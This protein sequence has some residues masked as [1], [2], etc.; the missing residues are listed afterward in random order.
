MYVK[1]LSAHRLVLLV[2]LVAGCWLCGRADSAATKIGPRSMSPTDLAHAI[3]RAIQE[4]LETEK[5][6]ASPR[7]DD[8]EFMRRAYLDVT[9]IIPTAEQAA[10]F[11][12]GKN[13]HKRA[14]LVNELLASPKYGQHMAD[15]W[16][17]L[18][19]P[20]MT[21]ETRALDTNALGR[22]LAERFNRNQ[23]WN[24][25]VYDFVTATG[26]V[27][28]NGA[29]AFFIANPTADK[30]T[31]SVTRLFLGI[32]LQC[33][34]CHNHPFTAWKQTEYWG[35]AAFFTK[36]KSDRAQAATK[37]GTSPG[38]TEMARGK[39][40][41]LPESAKIVPARFLTGEMPPLKPGEP[42]R[43]A[44]AKWLTSAGNPYFA[45]A[46]VNRMWGHFFGRGLVHPVDNMHDDNPASHPELLKLLSEQFAASGFDV[47]Q[48]I[49]AIC[50]S[51]AYQRTSKP[52]G[53]NAKYANLFGAVGIKALTPEQLFDSLTQVVGTPGA[54]A[55]GLLAKQKKQNPAATP[56]SQFAR[57]FRGDVEADS[58]EYDAGIP[59]ALRLMNSPMLNRRAVL[60]E[61]ALETEKS[62]ETVIAHLCL[63]T[64]S[65][66]PTEAERERFLS[67]V[68]QAGGNKQ[69]AFG[70]VLW[71][72]LNCSEFTLNH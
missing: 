57:F 34:Q 8:A 11:L 38:V 3:D 49:R 61:R 66:R 31:D 59:Q 12:D 2:A 39:G 26:T 64:L 52:A 68:Q 30:M 63:G 1:H 53:D 33:A 55:Q 48:L 20:G 13:P 40:P 25:L 16:Q 9:G 21:T 23:P 18:L 43:P 36:V 46:M 19:I 42:Q 67:F 37:K 60:L 56:R 28:H 51:E 45:R 10:R 4:R 41:K 47:K 6:A 62:P 22:W 27:D 71:V 70:D 44:L 54:F 7:A 69:K 72:L 24:E 32:Q 35:M 58:I 14:D 15:I 5:I 29:A 17:N 50:N 65:R